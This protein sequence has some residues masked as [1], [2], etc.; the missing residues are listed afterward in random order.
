MSGGMQ[1][2]GERIVYAIYILRSKT[3]PR[4]ARILERCKNGHREG[5]NRVCSA[6]VTAAHPCMMEGFKALSD[7]KV[8]TLFGDIL[9]ENVFETTDAAAQTAR[10]L[11][12][13]LEETASFAQQ[14][15]KG[16]SCP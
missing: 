16:N 4:P 6:C 9:A 13:A 15:E 8:Q 3:R 7:R 11:G 1:H 2:V 14:S 12:F 5:V 10:R